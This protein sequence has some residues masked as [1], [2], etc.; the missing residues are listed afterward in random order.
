ME[1]YPN[2]EGTGV[3]GICEEVRRGSKAGAW[4]ILN[5][6]DRSVGPRYVYRP[7]QGGYS[8]EEEGGVHQQGEPVL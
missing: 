5:L 2:V 8:M 6:D 7:A 4:S 1:S 3:L